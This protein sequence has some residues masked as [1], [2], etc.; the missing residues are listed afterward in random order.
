MNL[1][2]KSLMSLY[3]TADREWKKG[4]KESARIAEQ[5]LRAEIEAIE[6]RNEA[7]ERQNERVVAVLGR[8]S[9]MAGLAYPG[10]DRG[11]WSE[12][13]A[14]QVGSPYEPPEPRPKPTLTRYVSVPPPAP[15]FVS[16]SSCFVAGTPVHTRDGLRPIETLRVGDL[17][18]SQDTTTGALG[19]Q[20]VVAVLNRVAP[21]L[22]LRIADETIEATQI[23]RFWKAGQGWIMARDLK[24]GDILRTYDGLATVS[25]AEPEPGQKVFNLEV[26]T[27]QTFFVGQSGAL[28]HDN[29]LPPPGSVAF[30]AIPDLAAV[31]RGRRDQPS[32]GWVSAEPES[33]QRATCGETAGAVQVG[34]SQ[35]PPP[36]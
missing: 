7:I 22:R 18:L 32:T 12:W 10:T 14:E 29:R 31:A 13:W 17:V 4:L 6:R 26:G 19:F 34:R 11:A 8:V 20:P 23:H 3:N 30:D 27:Y 25:A 28:V 24:P 33:G 35:R 15:R 16:A 21:T 9:G 2:P 36:Q 5:A 1:T